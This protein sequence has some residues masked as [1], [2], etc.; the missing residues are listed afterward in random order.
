MPTNPYHEPSQENTLLDRIAFKFERDWNSTDTRPQIEGF[1]HAESQIAS[2]LVLRECLIVELQLRRRDGEEPAPE[3]YLSRFPEHEAVVRQVF[4][5][6]LVTHHDT[7]RTECQ[8]FAGVTVIEGRASL[9]RIGQY[10]V[11]ET[12]GQGGF[13]TVYLAQHTLLPNRRVAIKVPRADRRISSEQ[14]AMLLAEARTVSDLNHPNIV[15][16]IDVYQLGPDG[17][18]QNEPADDSIYAVVMEYVD[19]HSLAE[20]VS[21]QP[22]EQLGLPRI[23]EIMATVADTVAF[24][25]A[26]DYFHR[27]LKPA[28]ILLTKTGDVKIAD[29]GFALHASEQ[30]SFGGTPSYMSPEQ[31]EGKEDVT[32]GT[33]VWSIGVI[34]YQLL[35][36]RLPFGAPGDNLKL[37]KKILSHDPRPPSEINPTIP[38]EVA[39]ACL[40]CLQKDRMQRFL[41]AGELAAQLRQSIGGGSTP[42][43]PAPVPNVLRTEAPTPSNS[44]TPAGG[45]PATR[46]GAADDSVHDAALRAAAVARPESS[47]CET[48]IN[49]VGLTM[50]SLPAG[51]FVMGA[52]PRE[53][54]VSSRDEQPPHRVSI[55]AFSLGAYAVTCQQYA[56]VTGTELRDDQEPD[57]PITRISWTAAIRFCNRLSEL[58]GLTPYYEFTSSILPLIRRESIVVA[59]PETDGYRLPTEAEW[60]YACRAGSDGMWCFGDDEQLLTAYAWYGQAQISPAGQRHPNAWGIFD[61]HGNVWE[62]CWDIYSKRYYQQSPKA[63]PRGPSHGPHHVLRGGAFYSKSRDVRSAR[64]GKDAPG[65]EQHD[66]GFRVAR[67]TN[68]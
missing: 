9:S 67:S 66:V 27:D 48:S 59:H 57:Y 13:G 52:S 14:L 43:T 22:D 10:T 51:E 23:V 26:H 6:T 19:G 46:T 60:E 36:G 54:V 65:R 56:Q 12:L 35:T 4:N 20:V 41:S 15:Q 21:G 3:E 16:V 37:F 8:E 68:G 28:N 42:A 62:W 25:H 11:V 55:G 63:D 5:E 50:V 18:I 61:M 47:S 1:L 44:G 2:S 33:D 64:R 58:E 24:V 17:D 7:S 34:L 31:V 32:G 45:A 30:G 39:R 49:S 38:V 53:A 29:F 40:K